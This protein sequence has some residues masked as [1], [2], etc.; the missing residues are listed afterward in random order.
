[1]HKSVILI[2]FLICP[3]VLKPTYQQLLKEEILM[4]K[5]LLKSS[6]IFH[7]SSKIQTIKQEKLHSF[8]T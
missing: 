1:M 7:V 3:L 6:K 5:M 2:I 4:F 8:T